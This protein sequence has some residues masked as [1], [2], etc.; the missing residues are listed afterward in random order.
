MST[1]LTAPVA[2]GRGFTLV[3]L[4]I[5]LVLASGLVAFMGK[6]FAQLVGVAETA[7]QHTE[8][9]ER[10]THFLRFTSDLAAASTSPGTTE[11]VDLCDVPS[12]LT[13]VGLMVI[14]GAVPPCLSLP[15]RYSQTPVLVIDTLTACQ[16]DCANVGFPAYVWLQ[17]GCHPLFQITE[18]QLRF[19]R[20]MA[21]LEACSALTKI[22]HW[23]RQLIYLR[24][25]ALQPGDGERALMLKK[26]NSQ[27]LYGRA[28]MLVA[29]VLGWQFS[30]RP[31]ELS[32]VMQAKGGPTLPKA[33]VVER[34]P[35]AMQAWVQSLLPSTVSYLVAGASV[36]LA[37]GIA[38]AEVGS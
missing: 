22:S 28:E 30:E 8:L 31:Y 24:A 14:T 38:I 7:A 11:V 3:E 21:E 33:V 25:Y 9:T 18:P 6:A 17:P 37:S 29:K 36:R 1:K 20:D 23:Q 10:L 35:V 13:T 34:L 26:F 19:I 2:F 5:V 27:G 4:L 15:G 16:T 32:V 12:T